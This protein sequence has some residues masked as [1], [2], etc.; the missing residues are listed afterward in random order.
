MGRRGPAYGHDGK[1]VK[2]GATQTSL[3]DTDKFCLFRVTGGRKAEIIGP[4][5]AWRDARSYS[6]VEQI[7]SQNCIWEADVHMP[8]WHR[9]CI[10]S[11]LASSVHTKRA[12]YSIT[13][14]YHGE[15]LMFINIT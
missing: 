9:G 11:F 14:F 7:Q 5:A 2:Q 12:T 8:T 15:G 4:F 1:H 13:R 10:Y 3:F 6:V